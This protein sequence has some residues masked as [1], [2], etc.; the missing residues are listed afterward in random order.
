MEVRKEE[1]GDGGRGGHLEGEGGAERAGGREKRERALGGG[2][3]H[4]AVVDLK[5]ATVRKG[6]LG[7]YVHDEHLRIEIRVR[8][9]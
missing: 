3:G 7:L 1:E 4:C 9:R 2:G 6:I 8:D 5:G